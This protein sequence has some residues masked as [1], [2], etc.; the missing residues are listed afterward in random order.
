MK[1]GRIRVVKMGCGSTIDQPER[2][3]KI[4]ILYLRLAAL[5]PFQAYRTV[6]SEEVL[7]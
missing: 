5:S 3:G 1:S 7:R 6:V 4:T 2:V